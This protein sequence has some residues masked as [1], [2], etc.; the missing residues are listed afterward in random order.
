MDEW[1]DERAQ[2]LSI[3][4]PTLKEWRMIGLLKVCMWECLWVVA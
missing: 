4:L 2:V 1:I 3:G